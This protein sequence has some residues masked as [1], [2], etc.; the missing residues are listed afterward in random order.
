[1]AGWNVP[2]PPFP[3]STPTL[4]AMTS[5]I[6]SPLKSPTAKTSEVVPKAV[7]SCGL[8]VPSP[9]PS[10]IDMVPEPEFQHSDVGDPIAVEISNG[11]PLRTCAC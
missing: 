3:N 2:S 1:M 10:K 8:K 6:P 9:L 11:Y 5:G 7:T 4:F